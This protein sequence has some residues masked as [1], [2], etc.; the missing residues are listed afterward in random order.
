M[1]FGVLHD[2]GDYARRVICLPSEADWGV[3]VAGIFS[4]YTEVINLNVSS[5]FFLKLIEVLEHLTINQQPD[6]LTFSE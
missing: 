2:F 4:T 3:G 1:H 5:V 6:L